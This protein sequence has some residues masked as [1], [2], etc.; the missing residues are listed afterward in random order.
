M[1]LLKLVSSENLTESTFTNQFSIPLVLKPNSEIALKSL[2]MEFDSPS[3][4]IDDTNNQF[5]FR[6][7]A[8]ANPTHIVN[9]TNGKYNGITSLLK[10]IQNKMNNILIS[11]NDTSTIGPT[12]KYFQWRISPQESISGNLNVFMEYRCNVDDINPVNEASASLDGVSFTAGEFVKQIAD[13]GFFNAVWCAI[14]PVNKGGFQCGIKV[15]SPD[16]NIRNANWIWGADRSFITSKLTLKDDIIAGMWFCMANTSTGFYS[17]K[18]DGLMVATNIVIAVND[19]LKIYKENGKIQYSITKGV[20]PATVF[21]GDVINDVILNLG[22]EDANMCFHYGQNGAKIKATNVFYTPDPY[23]K[24]TN[25]VYTVSAPID[26]VETYYNSNLT[27]APS[28]MVCTLFLPSIGIRR[29]LGFSLIEYRISKIAS[30]F[31]SDAGGVNVNLVRE[32]LEVEIL[33]LELDNFTNTYKQ[34]RNMVMSISTGELRGSV[35]ASGNG[36]YTLSYSEPANFCFIELGN[37]YKQQHGQLTM[38]ITSAGQTIQ[39]SGKISA[40]LLYQTAK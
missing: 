18:K 11:K 8:G 35:V 39:M 32:D 7:R 28:N 2:T 21:E 16:T 30:A 10:E 1:K 12:D 29:L 24:G 38:R 36:K 4:V 37:E 13:D 26:S 40:L 33:E 5:S 19:I 9:I 23:I 14:I 15:T 27:G 3:F 20:N 25:G 6:T 31:V 34:K 17:F 22:S